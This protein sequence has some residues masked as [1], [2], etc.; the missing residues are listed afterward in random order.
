MRLGEGL[1]HTLN[2]E[3]LPPGPSVPSLEVAAIITK[4]S[5]KLDLTQA[6]ELPHH[7]EVSQ[8]VK[9]K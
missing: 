2:H 9:R 6:F 3:Q 4:C 7:S 1:V 8:D 5:N